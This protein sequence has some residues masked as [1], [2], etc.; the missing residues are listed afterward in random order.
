M[1]TLSKTTIAM[2]VMAVFPMLMM[3]AQPLEC[4]GITANTK[5]VALAAPRSGSLV[6]FTGSG[7]HLDP[8]PLLETNITVPDFLGRAACVTVTFS[9]QADPGDNYGV[10]QASIDDV[11]MSG[12]G[13]LAPE[14]GLTTPIVFDAVNQ[15]TFIPGEG[16]R[17]LNPANSRMVSYTFLAAVAPGAHTIRIRVAGC[18]SA[19]P[20]GIA[21]VFVRAATMVARW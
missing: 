18:C 1:R 10:Y 11:P 21:G 12:H 7:G 16:Y 9:A 17:F 4:Q 3:A 6:N 8:V 20:G 13:T 2:G 14:Y 15:G 5:A 19:A